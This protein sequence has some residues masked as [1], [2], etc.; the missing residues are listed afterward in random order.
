MPAGS[1]HQEESDGS[2]LRYGP[3]AGTSAEGRSSTLHRRQSDRTGEF[4]FWR[5]A[6][7]LSPPSL[8]EVGGGCL[9]L[10]GS[11][12]SPHHSGRSGSAAAAGLRPFFPQRSLRARRATWQA[13]TPAAAGGAPE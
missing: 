9:H 8:T 2:A 6:A 3:A 12:L 5:I 7:A 10:R 11:A 4:P 1:G 13:V